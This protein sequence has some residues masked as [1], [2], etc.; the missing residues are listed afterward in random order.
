MISVIQYIATQLILEH[1]VIYRYLCMYV[2]GCVTVGAIY[3]KK[4]IVILTPLV[5]NIIYSYNSRN[6]VIQYE[7]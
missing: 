5:V 1:S 7:N 6:Y 2:L 4:S 3:Y